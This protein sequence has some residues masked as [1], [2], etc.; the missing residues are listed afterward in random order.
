MVLT[1]LS[2]TDI[3]AGNSLPRGTVMFDS[4]CHLGDVSESKEALRRAARAGVRSVLCCGYDGAS[5]ERVLAL[6]KELPNLAV[7]IGLHPW[8]AQQAID[9]VVAAIRREEP[10]AIGEIGLERSERYGLPAPATQRHVFEIQLQL[11]AELKLPVTVHSFGAVS[12]VLE[13]VAAFPNVRGALHAYAGSLEQVKVLL[14]RG[15]K[16]G[17]GGSVTRAGA[18]RI[19]RLACALPLD[20]ILLETDCPSMAVGTRPAAEVR[21]EHL[22]EVADCLAI[23]RGISVDS[24]VEQ[25]NASAREL[26]GANV[27]D[28]THL[29]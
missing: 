25:T 15:W 13:V 11:A 21:P 28:S 3:E 5:N 6:R 26:F 2:I 8:F 10:S 27:V 29:G 17:L 12:L 24:L 20:A 14:N 7:A 22:V 18:R 1:S 19:R 23:L 9:P 4:H 16:V